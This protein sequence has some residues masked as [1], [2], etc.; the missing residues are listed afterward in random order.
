VANYSTMK[1][2]APLATFRVGLGW[3]EQ[4]AYLVR[5]HSLTLSEYGN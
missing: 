5:I 4:W 1:I 3:H 2:V